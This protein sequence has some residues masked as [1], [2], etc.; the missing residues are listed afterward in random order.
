MPE[1]ELPAALRRPQPGE[2]ATPGS[3][4]LLIELTLAAGEEGNEPVH[5]TMV[6]ARGT[7]RVYAFM[8]FDGMGERVPWTHVWYREVDGQMQE[9][10][11][12]TELWSYEYSR[13]R[14]WRYF[15]CDVGNYELRVYVG[16][17]L[18]QTV[19][20]VVQGR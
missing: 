6:F 14:I 8:F 18:Q 19:P 12:R 5:P 10:W 13:G 11:G 20:F 4:A 9:V 16:G 2:A 1:G 15:D 3:D 17:R 7:K